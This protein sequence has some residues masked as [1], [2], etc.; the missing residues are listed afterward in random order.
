MSGLPATAR[1]TTLADH[2]R[3]ARH[4]FHDLDLHPQRVEHP[5]DAR[6]DRTFAGSAGN[7]R[8]IAGVDGDE[9]GEQ[10][11]EL[12]AAAADERV[13]DGWRRAIDRDLR[14]AVASVEPAIGAEHRIL[15]TTELVDLRGTGLVAALEVL[16]S[17]LGP[18]PIAVD[19]RSDVPWKATAIETAEQPALVGAVEKVAHVHAANLIT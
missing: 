9:P 19:D 11:D 18:P 6:R 2:A 5:G 12:V 10:V 17:V 1:A 13:P 14:H 3:P 4:G 16:P 15:A 8:G 7:E